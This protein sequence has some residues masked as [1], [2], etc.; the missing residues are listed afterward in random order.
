MKVAIIGAGRMG[1]RFVQV[2]KEMGLELVAL[3][4][5]SSTNLQKAA[6]DHSLPSNRLFTQVETAFQETK[7]ECV[8]IATTAPVHA[9]YSC[10]AAK[11]GAKYIL[12]EKPMAVSLAECDRMISTC[13]EYGAALAVNHQMRFMEQYTKPKSLL[14]SQEFGGLTSISVV[15][16][17]FGLAMNGIHYLEMFRFMTDEEP[18]EVTAWLGSEKVPNPRGP[19]FEDHGGAMRV[20]TKSGKRF[21]LECSTDQGHGMR[22]IYASR[23]GQIFVDE[24]TGSLHSSV[25]QAEYRDLPTTRYGMPAVH[26]TVSI[27]PADA[28]TPSKAVLTALLNGK[29]Y[30]TAEEG[31]LAVAGLVAAVV[32]H[33]KGNIAV[34]VDDKLPRDRVFPWA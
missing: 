9:E 5:L 6:Q 22:V 12:S 32:S 34:R 28:T 30:P 11:K 17:N 3:A 25:R 1:S 19:Q 29:N 14:N 18:Y 33:E 23:Y 2:V 10:L 4:D 15:A 24:L 26:E 7:P 21:Y 20:T 13:R 27:A 31:R 16:G 8:V